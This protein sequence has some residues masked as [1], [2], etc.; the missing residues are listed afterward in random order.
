[1][2]LVPL[3]LINGCKSQKQGEISPPNVLFIAVDDLRL[4]A[5]IYGQPQ[6]VTPNID[7]LGKDGIVFNRAY[8]SVPVCGASR[9]SLLSGARP[10]FT[11]FVNYHT[12]KDVDLP[13]VPSLPKWFKD[14]GYTTVSNGKIYHHS[15]DDLE[16]WTEEPHIPTSGIGWQSY[17]TEASR[18]IIEKNR[19][20]EKPDQVIGPAY[21]HPDVEDNAYPDGQLA[22]KSI[23]DLRRLSKQENPFFL[24]VGFWKPHLPFNAPNKYWD[25]YSEKDIKLAD[26][27]YK[28]ENAPDAA[29]HKWG[30]LRSMYDNIPQEGPLSDEMA[31][32]LIHGY[33]AC[34]SYTDT[35]IGKLLDELDNLGLSENTIVILWGDHGWHL[36]EHTLWCKHC[37]FDR[38]MN[39]PLI[40]K[41]PGYGK[42]HASNAITEFIDIYPTL[43]ELCGLPEPG[44]LDGTSFVSVLDNPK[45]AV[46]D[47]AY[48]KYRGGESI[49]SNR[50]SYT[51]FRSADNSEIQDIMLYDLK[52]DPAENI[53]IS[54]R[55][56]MKPVIQQL[57]SQLAEIKSEINGAD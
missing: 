22:E 16:A 37:N 42:G 20:S 52:D 40:V 12:R 11:R 29:M 24:A 49:I 19:T 14:H 30:E 27:P 26:N 28:P 55:E 31:R 10:T 7:R 35:Q 33:Y 53:N 8:C 23:T 54:G 15:D 4:Q 56:N 51:E 18:G 34:V 57:S 25:L 13:G 36:G 1:M 45:Q 17:L 47:A 48:V 46:K 21:E 32:E 43:C 9:A 6:M 50:Y 39:A 3:L 5:N 38:V 2:G 44:H 41:A